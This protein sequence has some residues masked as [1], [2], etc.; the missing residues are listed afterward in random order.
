[1]NNRRLKALKGEE[2]VILAICLHRTIKNYNPPE[3][4]AGEVKFE[5]ESVGREKRRNNKNKWS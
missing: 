5:M 4:K 1:M 2:R 3:G